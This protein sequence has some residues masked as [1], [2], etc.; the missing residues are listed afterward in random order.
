[1]HS[2]ATVCTIGSNILHRTTKRW[3]WQ[4]EIGPQTAAQASIPTGPP[5]RE[6]AKSP[7][8]LGVSCVLGVSVHRLGSKKKKIAH[9]V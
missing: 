2:L 9:S 4:L 1:M 7:Q 3:E 6:Q 5:L 8:A